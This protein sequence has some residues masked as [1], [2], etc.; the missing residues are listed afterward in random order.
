MIIEEFHI[1]IRKNIVFK[2]LDCHHDNPAYELVEKTYKELEKIIYDYIK[3]KCLIFYSKFIEGEP[4]LLEKYGKEFFYVVM[5]IGGELEIRSKEC[6]NN[7]N[8]LEGM[9]FNAMAD[10][11][12]FQMEEAVADILTEECSK[13][14]KGIKQRLAAP[15]DIPIEFHNTVYEQ[16]N[17][18]NPQDIKITDGYMFEPVKTCCYVLVLS[19]DA[20]LFTFRH[21]CGKCQMKGCKL[22]KWI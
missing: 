2:L 6:F 19:D 10:D 11:Y 13:R 18:A 17:N 7:G 21:D 9:L 8:Y 1:T 3:P 15:E 12:L 14:G 5:T 16:I 20:N 4:N 22:R